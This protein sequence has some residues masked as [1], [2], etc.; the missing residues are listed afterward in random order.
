MIVDAPLIATLV[1]GFATVAVFSFLIKEN[2]LYRFFEHLFIGIAAGFGIVFTIKNF[3]WPRILT[4]MLGADIVVFPDGTTSKEYEPFYL[5]YLLPM[6]FGLLYYFIYS[7]RYGW[8]AKLV[9]GFS[10]GMSGGVALKAFINEMVPQIEGSFKP[11]VVLDN[12]VVNWVHSFEN[13]FFIVTLVSVMYYFFFSFKHEGRV[14]R[15]VA[16][17]GRWLMMIVFGAFFGSTVMARMALL[18]ERV[19]F[20]LQDWVAA[21]TSSLGGVA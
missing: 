16:S 12:G 20:L 15:G 6:A 11:L 9:I 17:T 8:L 19:Q 18:V 10:L 2:P 14:S 3:L 7:R 1:G 4:P 21:L 5:L 13:I